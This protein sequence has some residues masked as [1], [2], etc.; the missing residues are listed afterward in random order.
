M[1]DKLRRRLTYANVMAT[2]ALFIALGGTSYAVSRIDGKLLKNRSVPGKKLKRNAVGPFEVNEAKLGQVRSAARAT[3]ADKAT[4]ADTATNAGNANTVG[5][6][7]VGTFERTTRILFGIKKANGTV[8]ELIIDDPQLGAQ[9]MTDGDG[10]DGTLD[11][12]VKNTRAAGGGTLAMATGLGNFNFAAPGQSAKIGDPSAISSEPKLLQV[13]IT[14]P[15]GSGRS[16]LV[17]CTIDVSQPVAD[18]DERCY[19]LRSQA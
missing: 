12:R 13:I 15:G 9:V 17:W 5:G 10:D 1:L 2:L 8:P 14:E 19:G 16:L 11:V 3:L 4:L 6:L 7:G 18:R